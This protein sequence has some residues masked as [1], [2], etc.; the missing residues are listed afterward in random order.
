R[1]VLIGLESPNRAGLDGLER[2]ANWKLRQLDRY[3]A[4]VRRIQ[5]HGV[6]V[7]GCFILGLDGDTE[8]VFDAIYDFVARTNLFEVHRVP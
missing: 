3:E 5:A 7:N 8:A 2:R 6:T 4:G 1:Q